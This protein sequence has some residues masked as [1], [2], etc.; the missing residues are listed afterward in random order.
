MDFLESQEIY[1]LSRDKWLA[2]A[3]SDNINLAIAIHFPTEKVPVTL[4]D[5]ENEWQGMVDST[6]T[7]GDQVV[8]SINNRHN[9]EQSVPHKNR[10]WLPP[11]KEKKNLMG[12]GEIFMESDISNPSRNV[13]I[14]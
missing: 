10:P 8:T 5:H 12:V 2:K 4:M 3:W 6:G 14:S 9:L 11:T 13:E 1:G 7:D